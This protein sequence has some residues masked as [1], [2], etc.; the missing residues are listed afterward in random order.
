MRSIEIDNVIL[1]HSKIAEQTGGD[2]KIRDA[3]LIDAAIKRA[4]ASFDSNDLYPASE[5]KIAAISHGLIKNRGFMD[6]NKR[7]GVCMM[8]LLAKTNGINLDYT[9]AELVD[10]GLGTAEGRYD[11]RY[12]REWICRHETP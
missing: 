3:S 6:G 12:I 8:L 2:K 9:Q 5:D 11:E 7:I 1:F 10:L 4:F